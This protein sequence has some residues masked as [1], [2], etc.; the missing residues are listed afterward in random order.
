VL[1]AFILTFHD[2]LEAFLAIGVCVAMLK[3]SAHA[4][5]LPAVRTGLLA[6][7]VASAVLGWRFSSAANPAIWEG[8]MSLLAAVA[9]A[10]LMP[11]LWRRRSADLGDTTRVLWLGLFA[12]TLLIVTREGMETLLL[13][14]TLIV[15]VQSLELIAGAVVGLGS[16]AVIAWLWARYGARVRAQRL[17][18]VTA[19]FLTLLLGLLL[20][21][22]GYELAEARLLPGSTVIAAALEP[23]AP[24]G[25]YGQFSSELLLLV[26]GAWLVGAIL[27]GNGQATNH[28]IAHL[29]R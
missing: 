26:P 21:D 25:E 3:S 1:Q 14:A 24:D 7:L 12:F 28:R 18:P 16:S 22:A 6:S 9:V 23:L 2:G 11:H 17:R 15:Q 29:D 19:L 20:V 27:W 13:V 8:G 4:R 5:L 10:F